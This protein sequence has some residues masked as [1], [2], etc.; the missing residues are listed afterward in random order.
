MNAENL[1]GEITPVVDNDGGKY[2]IK[3]SGGCIVW[4]GLVITTVHP[5]AIAIT[6]SAIDF[7]YT[8]GETAVIRSYAITK[9]DGKITSFTNPDGTITEVLRDG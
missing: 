5:T 8:V 9:T 6:D 4:D 2:G 3:I 1:I 7:S